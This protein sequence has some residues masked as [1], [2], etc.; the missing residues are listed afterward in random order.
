MA[1]WHHC[2]AL[3]WQVDSSQWV[4]VR[5]LSESRHLAPTWLS[6]C[7][8]DKQTNK[9]TEQNMNATGRRKWGP[10]WPIKSLPTCSETFSNNC[11]R[12]TIK[13][14]LTSRRNRS[15]HLL[16]FKKS[17]LFFEFWKCSHHP[18][19][20]PEQET[21]E[22]GISLQNFLTKLKKE[23]WAMNDIDRRWL[24]NLRKRSLLSTS[25]S[26]SLSK[27][28]TLPKIIITASAA[29]C[30]ESKSPNGVQWVLPAHIFRIGGM[31]WS[32]LAKRL[33]T[34]LL[35]WVLPADIPQSHHLPRSPWRTVV[36][37]IQNL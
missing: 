15:W 24:K 28:S 27:P 23:I 9:Q 8:G 11:S 2:I 32:S 4:S 22:R 36:L 37:G 14:T 21:N 33:S 31:V 34:L 12:S 19:T 5:S 10:V 3:Q 17:H 13:P 35:Q 20:L 18:P 26:K 7:L 25:R 16:N 30:Q 6:L 1:S 29:F